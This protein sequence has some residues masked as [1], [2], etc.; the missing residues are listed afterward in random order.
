VLVV[1][2]PPF[3][4]FVLGPLFASEVTC[5][6]LDLDGITSYPTVGEDVEHL[7]AD[8]HAAVARAVAERVRALGW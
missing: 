8:G 2:P 3:A 7:D 1:C 4:G 6:V 5:P